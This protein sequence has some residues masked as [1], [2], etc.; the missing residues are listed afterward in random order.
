MTA[1]IKEALAAARQFVEH[2]PGSNAKATLVKIDAALASLSCGEARERIARIIDPNAG[3]GVKLDSDYLDLRQ[4]QAKMEDEQRVALRKA[5]TILATG[6]VPG[7]ASIRADE[8]EKCAS[9]AFQAVTRVVISDDGDTVLA[10]HRYWEGRWRDADRELSTLRARV[11]EVVGPFA[12]IRQALELISAN[13]PG[14]ELLDERAIFQ[15]WGLKDTPTSK[16]ITLGHLRAARQLM[17]EVK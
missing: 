4:E 11:R 16:Q 14:D 2:A 3:W 17:E 7:E 5:D 8:R 15:T 13:K 9:D 10:D 6:C 12:E 1:S